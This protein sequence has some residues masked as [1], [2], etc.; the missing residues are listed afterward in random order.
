[1]ELG[2]DEVIGDDL[3]AGRQRGFDPRLNRQA[4]LASLLRHQSGSDHHRWVR[5]VSAARDRSDH[6]VAVL[7]LGVLAGDDV[8]LEAWKLCAVIGLGV[9]QRDAV[10]RPP[11]A[12]DRGNN[13]AQINRNGVGENRLNRVGVVPEALRAGVGLDDFNLLFGATG[14]AQITD[15]LSVDR[16][17]CAGRPKL[18]AHVA[19]RGAVGKRELRNA[20]AVELNERSNYAALTQQLGDGQH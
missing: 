2:A 4:A 8:A 10:L 19:E 11:R 16:E 7:Q 6:D 13:V 3:R 12:G 20:R 15:C 1:M 17:D 18:R 5:G 9:D 14:E